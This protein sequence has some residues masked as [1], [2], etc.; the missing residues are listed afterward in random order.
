[1]RK[2]DRSGLCFSM[3]ALLNRIPLIFPVPRIISSVVILLRENYVYGTA[4]KPDFFSNLFM[5]IAAG[6]AMRVR[7]K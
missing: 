4:L 2:E 1:M 5:D 7:P 3:A 6:P